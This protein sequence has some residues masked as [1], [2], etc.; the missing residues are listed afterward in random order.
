MSFLFLRG[1]GR[2]LLLLFPYSRSKNIHSSLFPLLLFSSLCSMF[3]VRAILTKALPDFETSFN[4]PSGFLLASNS[5]QTADHS[6][7]N[8]A[9][10]EAALI[11]VDDRRVE[12]MIG[13][14]I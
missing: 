12:V 7:E 6:M 14:L 5:L 10:R 2:A 4:L 13:S 11:D 3:S 1:G 8:F 9:G